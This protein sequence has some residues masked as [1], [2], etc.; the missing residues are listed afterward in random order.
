VDDKHYEAL[1]TLSYGGRTGGWG[2]GSVWRRVG[3]ALA[4]AGLVDLWQPD[5]DN[6]RR[7]QI[8]AKL[9]EAGWRAFEGERRARR[10]A[11]DLS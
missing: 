8:G 3:F 1:H 2:D 9:T 4:D 5:V 6:P 10:A 7:R 11:A